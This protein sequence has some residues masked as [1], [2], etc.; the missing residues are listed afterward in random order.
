MRRCGKEIPDERL[1]ALIYASRCV[2]CE[3]EAEQEGDD[4]GPGADEDLRSL[5]ADVITCQAAWSSN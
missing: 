1:K 3:Q 5:S 2:N 4:V